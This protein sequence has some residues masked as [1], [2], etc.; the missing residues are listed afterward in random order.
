M[1]DSERPKK[2]KVRFLGALCGCSHRTQRSKAFTAE[3]AKKRRAEAAEYGK[4]GMPIW[5]LA[6]LDNPGY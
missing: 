6:S 2:R 4:E 3:V 5:L 1:L